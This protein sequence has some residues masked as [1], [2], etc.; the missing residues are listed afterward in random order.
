MILL[1]TVNVASNAEA[2]V[3]SVTLSTIPFIR[4]ASLP[5]T[6]LIMTFPSLEELLHYGGGVKN[7]DMEGTTDALSSGGKMQ[8]PAKAGVPHKDAYAIACPG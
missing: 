1:A 6:F 4:L 8:I 2:C 5:L 7:A 3:L